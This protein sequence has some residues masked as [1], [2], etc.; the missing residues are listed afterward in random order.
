LLALY[1]LKS[2]QGNF[3][4]DDCSAGTGGRWRQ[5]SGAG[6]IRPMM[7]RVSLTPQF[8]REMEL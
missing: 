4:E 6:L 3:H 5:H 1:C 7:I 8:D 2:A